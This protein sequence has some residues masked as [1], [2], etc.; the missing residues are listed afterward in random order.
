MIYINTYAATTPRLNAFKQICN[1]AKDNGDDY[2]D[3]EEEVEAYE[4][5]KKFFTKD[6]DLFRA[7]AAE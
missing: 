2:I 6:K 1:S 3:P 7:D 4:L 5:T